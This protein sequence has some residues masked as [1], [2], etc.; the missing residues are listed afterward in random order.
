MKKLIA[1]GGLGYFLDTPPPEWYK[2][3]GTKL[4]FNGTA[5]GENSTTEDD[6]HEVVDTNGSKYTAAVR[7]VARLAGKLAWV[8]EY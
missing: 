4:K 8:Q 1:Q 7:I 2:A 5:V 3:V 6:D